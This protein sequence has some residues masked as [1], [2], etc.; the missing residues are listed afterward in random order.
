MS[1]FDGDQRAEVDSNHF[2]LVHSVSNATPHG[3]NF[4]LSFATKTK[5]S[6]FRLT[7]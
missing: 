1:E 3:L 6:A 5:L 4:L 7:I 2:K